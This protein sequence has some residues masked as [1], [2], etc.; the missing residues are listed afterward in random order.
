MA[1]DVV[2]HAVSVIHCLGGYASG[3]PRIRGLRI[4]LVFRCGD[5]LVIQ[6]L[7]GPIEGGW[8]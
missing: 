3:C 2:S 7:E 8:F 1:D 4:L 5:H 6:I